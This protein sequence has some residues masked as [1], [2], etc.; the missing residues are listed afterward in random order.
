LLVKGSSDES[1][2]GFDIG[3]TDGTFGEGDRV[4]LELVG[5]VVGQNVKLG[6]FVGGSDG[7]RVGSFGLTGYSVSYD[8][9]DKPLV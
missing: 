3:D 2:E 8:S 4:G 5:E 9:K 1:V 6:S 7:A